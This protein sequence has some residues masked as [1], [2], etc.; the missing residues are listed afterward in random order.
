MADTEVPDFIAEEQDTYGKMS[1]AAAAAYKFFT[2]FRF[3]DI[4]SGDSDATT[5]STQ[6]ATIWFG[7]Q[8]CA[9]VPT[10]LAKQVQKYCK[11]MRRFI[12]SC[13][14]TNSAAASILQRKVFWFMT[15]LLEHG[16]FTTPQYTFIKGYVR[17]VWEEIEN[18]ITYN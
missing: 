15:M 18:E 3:E 4:S 13:P 6:S 8:T 2:L 14:Q 11:E 7:K 9:K 5:S 10:P 17:I 12:R 16:V 1:R